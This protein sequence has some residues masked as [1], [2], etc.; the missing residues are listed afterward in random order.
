MSMDRIQ[1][2]HARL[3]ILR[4]L[5]DEVSRTSNSA[6]LQDLLETYGIRRDRDWVHQ[7]IAYL[8]SLAAVTVTPAGDRIRIVQLTQRGL[9]HVDG[10]LILEG[11]RR[12]SLGG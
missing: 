11:V 7:E 10:R 12:P 9:D 8:A 2:E 6:S 1:R 4:A 3:I 5:V